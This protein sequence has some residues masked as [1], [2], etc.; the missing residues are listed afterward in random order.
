MAQ[1]LEKLA[2]MPI[3]RDGKLSWPRWLATYRYG[4]PVSRQSPIKV[5]AGSDVEQLRWS[6]R[7][8]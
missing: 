3:R 6:R 8:S 5:V 7:T 1:P 4:L 2:R